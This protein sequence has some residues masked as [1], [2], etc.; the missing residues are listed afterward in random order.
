M[1]SIAGIVLSL[2]LLMA[3]AYRGVSVLLLAP[4]MALLAVL[5]SPDAPLL[6]SYTQVFMK[7]LG[8]FVVLYFPLFLLGAVFGKLMEASRRGARRSRT[9]SPP[10][11]ARARHP[12]DRAGLRGAHLRRRVAVRGGLRRLPDRRGAVPRGRRAPSG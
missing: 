6:A 1:T 10:A 4:L 9:A 5:F 8:G 2:V 11:G 3:L 12:G 7:A